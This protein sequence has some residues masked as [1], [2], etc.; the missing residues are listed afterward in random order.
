M[1]APRLG[2]RPEGGGH[3]SPRGDPRAGRAL[4]VWGQQLSWAQGAGLSPLEPWYPQ[5]GRGRGGCGQE[6]RAHSHKGWAGT[7]R[8]PG[9]CGAPGSYSGL[10]ALASRSL[11]PRRRS[12]PGTGVQGR[13]TRARP[14]RGPV[15]L[16]WLRAH[17]STSLAPQIRWDKAAQTE[18]RRTLLPPWLP[19]LRELQAPT[20]LGTGSGWLGAGGKGLPCP[21]RLDAA[22]R[23]VRP[24]PPPPPPAGGR[25]RVLRLPTVV[26][27]TLRTGSHE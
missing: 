26:S 5:T 16:I 22:G 24:P 4:V 2:A 3:P 13:P 17:G 14:E 12:D 11:A 8:P 18:E 6:R 1:P 23:R 9:P 10:H 21:T 19:S 7:G 27:A 20:G 25:P 15:C